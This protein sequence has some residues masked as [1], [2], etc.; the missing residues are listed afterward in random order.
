MSNAQTSLTDPSR[1]AALYR[2]AP[3]AAATT[4]RG[5]DPTRAEASQASA[6][7]PA[8]A[9]E[10]P[11]LNLSPSGLTAGAMAAVTSA[12]VGSQLGTAGTLAGAALGSLIGAV[13]TALYSFSIQRTVHAVH[14][15]RVSARES[16]AT[17]SADAEAAETRAS[18]HEVPRTGAQPRAKRPIGRVAMTVGIAITA[19]AA[20]LIALVVIT[21]IEKV[22]GTT[23]SGN[24]GTTV[25]EIQ[26]ARGP[27]VVDDAT[28]R[29]EHRSEEP[30]AAAAPT[31]PTTP[32]PAP[33]AT[34]SASPRPTPTRSATP[35]PASPAPTA[36]PKP[37]QTATPPAAASSAQPPN[38]S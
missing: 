13:A 19:V 32:T 34:T 18:D 26:Q 20:F 1:Y 6:P 33:S 8:D 23:L 9:S 30:A 4:A 35:A 27:M 15:V 11:T 28:T 36:K 16:H 3:G 21:G 29:V 25:R 38:L 10:K 17:D 37:K 5:A 2:D 31:T 7:A 12:V 22:S 24:P 14:H